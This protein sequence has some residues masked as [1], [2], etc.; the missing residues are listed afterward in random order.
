VSKKLVFWFLT[1]V[2]ILT[3]AG[4]FVVAEFNN[5]ENLAAPNSYNSDSNA[6]GGQLAE[7]A[8]NNGDGN[9]VP[10]QKR[11][12]NMKEFIIETKLVSL[13]PLLKH[14][15]LET[16]DEFTFPEDAWIVGFK[17]DIVGGPSY[18]LHH[19]N[20]I[21]KSN[22][23]P[24]CTGPG[25]HF[26]FASGE[27][28]GGG[29]IPEGYGIPM[30]RGDEIIGHVM[31]HN[32]GVDE[33]SNIKSRLTIKYIEKNE[34]QLKTVWPLPLDLD[35]PCVF[36]D[37]EVPVGEELHRDMTNP[38]RVNFDGQ[39]VLIGAHL[40]KYGENL[41]LKLNDIPIGNFVP[42][43]DRAGNLI[44]IPLV[45]PQNLLLKPGDTLSIEANYANNS[46]EEIDAMAEALLF[47]SVD[48][49]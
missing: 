9:S 26:L 21:S 22:K 37:Y 47:I 49:E 6:I 43:K 25:S 1:L 13:P 28:L 35:G 48:G 39:I 3:I 34:K 14:P 17:I 38:F 42:K 29:E 16:Y 31:Y 11:Y 8:I 12:P 32:E 4:Y 40:H 33:R 44:S 24:F 23:S 7:Q 18:L 27:E 15:G 10:S 30:E 20:Y 36:N 19:A 2:I 46:D 45:Y 5:A 41:M